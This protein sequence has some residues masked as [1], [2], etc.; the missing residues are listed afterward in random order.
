[1]GISNQNATTAQQL[2]VEGLSEEV[3]RINKLIKKI[4]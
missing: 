2:A 1:M 3:M 4:I